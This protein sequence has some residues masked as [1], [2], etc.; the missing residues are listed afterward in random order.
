MERSRNTENGRVVLEVMISMAIKVEEGTRDG[1]RADR[2]RKELTF[3]VEKV[4]EIA[5]EHIRVAR[6][7]KKVEGR[8]RCFM[9][10]YSPP[11]N[12]TG[13]SMSLRAPASEQQAPVM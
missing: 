6:V 2:Q 9:C 1:T 3:W 4:N 13:R 7:R 11:D 8:E 5:R 10:K 12:S